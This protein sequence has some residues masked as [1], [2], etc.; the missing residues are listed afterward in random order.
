MVVAKRDVMGSEKRISTQRDLLVS[1]TRPNWVEV[2]LGALDHNMTVV[3]RMIGSNVRLHACIKS[4][5]YGCDV[6][7][8]AKRFSDLGADALCCGSFDEAVMVRAALPNMQLIMFGATLPEGIPLYLQH[9]LTPTIHNIEL[10]GAVSVSADKPTKVH[11]KV[12]AGGGRIGFPLHQAKS[13]IS[14]IASMKNVVVEA[15]YTHVPF[16]DLSGKDFAQQKTTEFCDMVEALR[17]EGL[18]IPVTQARASSGVIFGLQDNCNAVAI[19]SLLYGKAS[20]PRDLADFS[21]LRPALRAVK[22][23][24]IHVLP[25]FPGK[26]VGRTTGVHGR[27][28]APFSGATGVIPFGWRDGYAPS[29]SRQ[30]AYV[31]MR[32]KRV[33]VLTVNSELSVIDLTD[34][35][36]PRIGEQ[37]TIVGTDG[38][39]TITLDD[40]SEWQGSGQ[41]AVLARM[42]NRSPKVFVN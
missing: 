14:E 2:D 40:L 32:G 9:G 12:D 7:E 31:L 21:S 16:T 15:V 28:A 4:G 8:V 37:V 36:D 42:N 5:A 26:T 3:R 22:S 6:L 41:S 13:A 29:T 20:A 34:L 30:T 38:D 11:I 19:S 17:S 27:Q 1:P 10:A 35:P 18:G 39:E 33:P 25:D 23:Q 24:L